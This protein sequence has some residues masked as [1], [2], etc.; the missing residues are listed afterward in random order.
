M[1]EQEPKD[2]HREIDRQLTDAEVFDFF[3]SLAQCVVD[4]GGITV[5]DVEAMTLDRSD[6]FSSELFYSRWQGG[7]QEPRLHYDTVHL[8]LR[9]AREADSS[10][11]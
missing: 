9:R 1:A 7:L 10:I 4:H 5:A 8:P 2:S 3:R 11:G 6:A